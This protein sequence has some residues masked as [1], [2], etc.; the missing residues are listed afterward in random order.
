[1]YL[2]EL[3]FRATAVKKQRVIVYLPDYLNLPPRHNEIWFVRSHIAN[4][5]GL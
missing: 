3:T 4:F 1:M 2:H 5:I